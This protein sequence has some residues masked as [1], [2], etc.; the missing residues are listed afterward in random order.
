MNYLIIST[1]PHYFSI[2]PV[3][4]FY[5]SHTFGYINTIVVSTTFSILYHTY[6]ESNYEIMFFD[7]LLAFLWSTYEMYFSAVYFGP[8]ATVDILFLNCVL[9]MWNKSIGYNNYYIFNHSV[10]HFANAFKCF[11]VSSL[12]KQAL[13]H[14]A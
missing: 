1:L 12:I 7:Y 8:V 10:W 3:M 6:E 5:N 9:L 13:E 14:P 2:F 11:Y 4:S